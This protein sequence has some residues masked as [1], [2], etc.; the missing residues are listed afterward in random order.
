MVLEFGHS[1]MR[2]F[3]LMHSVSIDLITSLNFLLGFLSNL[4]SSYPN[5]HIG[6]IQYATQ[7]NLAGFS[8]NAC[9]MRFNL[10]E[11]KRKFHIALLLRFDNSTTGHVSR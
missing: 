2:A 6:V 7:A 3:F 5:S 11:R 4:N 10:R 9:D 8:A 1:G